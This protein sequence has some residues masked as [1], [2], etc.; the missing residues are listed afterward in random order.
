MRITR[1]AAIEV[2]P[3][4]GAHGRQLQRERG[5]SS[6]RRER[7]W[8]TPS[9]TGAFRR[10]A[11]PVVRGRREPPVWTREHGRARDPV[12][13][14]KFRERSRLLAR[15]RVLFNERRSRSPTRFRDRFQG[16]DRLWSA[17]SRRGERDCEDA[18]LSCEVWTMRPRDAAD[19]R[20]AAPRRLTLKGQHPD[21]EMACR[22]NCSIAEDLFECV[23][24]FLREP[25][26]RIKS[27]DD[28]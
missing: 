28:F 15:T 25:I 10:Q 24:S 4:Y 2:A 23:K 14:A 22:C 1:K 17:A 27:R 11:L 6:K 8:S 13:F 18:G 12:C 3:N 26:A 7:S 21:R 16:D 19:G 9:S 5:C 20:L